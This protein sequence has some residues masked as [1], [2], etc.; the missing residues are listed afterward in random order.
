M[1]WGSMGVW[2]RGQA[3]GLGI[4]FHELGIDGCVLCGGQAYRVGKRTDRSQPR[5]SIARQ[6]SRKELLH[7]SKIL[8]SGGASYCW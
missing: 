5:Q 2:W 6:R 4:Y 7:C 3:D 8:A 1:N